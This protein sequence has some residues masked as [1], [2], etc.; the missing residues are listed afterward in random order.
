M[1]KFIDTTKLR[2]RDFICGLSSEW[3]HA[4]NL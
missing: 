4:L 2:T 3:E 1:I